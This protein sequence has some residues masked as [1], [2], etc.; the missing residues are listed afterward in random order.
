MA[1]R[2]TLESDLAAL[3]YRLVE[4][5]K[6]V[7]QYALQVNRYLTYWVHWTPGAGEVLFTWECAIGEFM[8]D[9]GLQLGSNEA[10]NSFLFPQ[11]D[12]RGPEDV[13]FVVQEMD[14]AERILG[15]LNPVAPEADG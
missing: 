7:Y 12:A 8:A 1:E 11:H 9:R 5:R 15:S 10:L 2:E 14:R 13:A 4:E 3:G 6:G